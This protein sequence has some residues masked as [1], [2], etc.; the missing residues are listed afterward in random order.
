MIVGDVLHKN[1]WLKGPKMAQ[2]YEVL[3][4]AK[5][6]FQPS[7]SD[8]FWCFPIFFRVQPLLMTIYNV[9][10]R[11]NHQ[12]DFFPT[13]SDGCNSRCKRWSST[14]LCPGLFST[15]KLLK[16]QISSNIQLAGRLHPTCAPVQCGR[17]NY[18][19]V[20]NS[21]IQFNHIYSIQHCESRLCYKLIL[22]CYLFPRI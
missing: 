1:S 13:I 3:L 2:K 14:I 17:G 4:F 8:V 9:F 7:F 22:C 19:S 6:L 10:F 20:W 21:L 16:P 18:T 11:C 12:N 5:T 15:F